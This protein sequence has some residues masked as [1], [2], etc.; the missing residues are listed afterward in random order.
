MQA[1]G[2]VKG[3]TL[4]LHS[5]R[6]ADYYNERSNLCGGESTVSLQNRRISGAKRET[7]YTSA[8]RDHEHFFDS[9]FTLMVA[10]RA[11]VS[12]FAVPPVLSSSDDLQVMPEYKGTSMTPAPPL[13][14]TS[15]SGTEWYLKYPVSE[16]N[17]ILCRCPGTSAPA[18]SMNTA[19][20]SYYDRSKVIGKVKIAS[21]V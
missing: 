14:S 21:D 5:P 13:V 18:P 15:Y 6:T 19:L 8:E 3:D 17:T 9:R 12:R 11:R 4:H 20:A 16:R 1:R 10:L 2:C 7:R